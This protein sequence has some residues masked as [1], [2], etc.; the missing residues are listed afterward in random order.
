MTDQGI[1]SFVLDANVFME[2]HRRYYTQDLCP[3]F[4]ECLIHYCREGRVF[5]IDRV[6]DEVLVNQDQLSEWVKQAPDSLFVSLAAEPV[7]NT[8]TEMMNW[9]QGNSQ[10]KPEA[11]TDFAKAADGWVVAYA[12]VHNAVVVTHEGFNATIK[13]RVPIPNV[14]RQSDVTCCNTFTMLRKLEVHFVWA[15]PA[16]PGQNQ[17]KDEG[18]V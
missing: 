13:K 17:E 14:C 18:S 11:K 5:S 3:G 16:A 7:I 10:F 15:P 8:F 1:P 4:W 12:R 6:L 2:A 9:V